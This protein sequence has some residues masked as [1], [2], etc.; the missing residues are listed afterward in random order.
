M[1]IEWN[2]YEVIYNLG[3]IVVSYYIL[4][5]GFLVVAKLVTKKPKGKEEIL[6]TKSLMV[7][8]GSGGHTTEMLLMLEQL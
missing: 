5:V 1:V 6:K 3:M 2:I 4:V 7:V 8:F